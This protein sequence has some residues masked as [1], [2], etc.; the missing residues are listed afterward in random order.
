MFAALAAHQVDAVLLDTVEVLAEAKQSQ[1]ALT[2]V[3][4]YRTGGVYGAMLPKGSPNLNSVNLLIQEMQSD[5]ELSRLSQ[6]YLVPEFGR[7]P[8]TVPYLQA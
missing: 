4:Q 7:N 5:G 3:G 6:E 8:S 2:V 1:G